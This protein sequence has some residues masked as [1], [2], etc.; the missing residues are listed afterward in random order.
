MP[1]NDELNAPAVV[2]VLKG[3]ENGKVLLVNHA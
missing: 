3:N 2:P 1:V